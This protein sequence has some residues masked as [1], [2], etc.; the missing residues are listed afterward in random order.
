MSMPKEQPLDLAKEVNHLGNIVANL[1]L[2]IRADL[3]PALEKISNA[4]ADLPGAT[5]AK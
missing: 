1:D 4:L 3:I 2:T 5:P